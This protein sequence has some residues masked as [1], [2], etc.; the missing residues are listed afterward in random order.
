[1]WLCRNSV[2]FRNERPQRN[3]KDEVL[4]KASEFAFI[5]INKKQARTCTKIKVNWIK[6]PLNW[7]KLN[8]NG[9]SLGNPRLAGRGGLI[10][11]DKGEWIKCYARAVELTANVAMELWAS[12]D[13]IRLCISL[14]L[15]AVI[16]ELDVQL[17]VDL[18]KKDDGHPNSIDALVS[19]FK[20]GLR[21]ILRCTDKGTSM[22]TTTV[23]RHNMANWTLL[24]YRY[25]ISNE[26]SVHPRGNL[27]LMFCYCLV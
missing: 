12:R 23:W 18:L 1:M 14:K 10:W 27:W 17:I 25:D 24:Q 8:L 22:G 19:E 16:I 2:I 3:L 9:L 11:N 5:G 4:W 13:G 7:F 21:E 20:T 6:P 26:I 15:P